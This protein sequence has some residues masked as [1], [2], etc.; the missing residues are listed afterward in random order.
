MGKKKEKASSGIPAGAIP[1]DFTQQ[2]PNHSYSPP[3]AYYVDRAYVC[4]DCGRKVI[5]TAIQQKWYYEVAKGSLY[6]TAIRCLDCRKK[7]KALYNGQGDPHPIK[8]L[9]TLF[10][11]IRKNVDPILKDAGFQFDRKFL[12]SNNAALDYSRPGLIFVVGYDCILGNLRLFV[13]CLDEQDVCHVIHN[14]SLTPTTQIVEEIE[15]L[16]R[17]V[18]EY[19]LLH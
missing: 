1:A 11:R 8:H 6:A 14:Q 17:A 2:V 18:R 16:T 12:S 13:E 7:R 5:W 4:V 15:S 10:K 19:F 9:G 3:P